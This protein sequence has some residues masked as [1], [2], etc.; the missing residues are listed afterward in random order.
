MT[1]A[2]VSWHSTRLP[3]QTDG[4]EIERRA[5]STA[6]S[7]GAAR[8]TVRTGGWI[9]RTGAGTKRSPLGGLVWA[10]LLG[11]ASRGGYRIRRS[12]RWRVATGRPAGGRATQSEPVDNVEPDSNIHA[13]WKPADTGVHDV[14]SEP[15]RR[16]HRWNWI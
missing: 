6:I 13:D 14:C 16:R 8:V 3:C 5:E 9:G 7:S 4:L 15:G 2:P 11:L 1:F 12:C 10:A